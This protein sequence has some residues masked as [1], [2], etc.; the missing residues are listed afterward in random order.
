VERLWRHLPDGA[1]IGHS[2]ASTEAG[3]MTMLTMER[4]WIPDGEIVPVGR[5]LPNV[6]IR[7]LDGSGQPAP[8]GEV[9]EM[10]VS[11]PALTPGYWRDPE[12]TAA[13]FF[14]DPDSGRRFYRLGDLARWRPDGLLELAGRRDFQVKIR[15]Y[16]V[17]L[18]E[19]EANLEQLPSVRQAL[20]IADARSEREARLIAYV[21]PTT[22]DRFSLSELRRELAGRL[23]AYMIPAAFI[24]MERLPLMTNGKIDRRALPPPSSARPAV[25]TAYIAPRTPIEE[26]VAAIWAEVLGLERVGVCD[27]FLDLGGHSLQVARIVSRVMDTCQVEI[28][29]SALFASPTVAD[30]ALAITQQEA[31]HL[32]ADELEQLLASV[33]AHHS[34]PV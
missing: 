23:P 12:L 4:G 24:V 30:M 5:P 15:G 26:K 13:K 21:A 34:T 18:G 3:V 16:R 31:A 7:L 10:M 33:E 9:G 28:P 17:E 27:N 8:P 20:V 6:E 19:V 11:S 22:V 2:L 14:V 32:D 29:L 25:D 1:Q